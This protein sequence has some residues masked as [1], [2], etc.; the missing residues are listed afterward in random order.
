MSVT[1]YDFCGA[2]SEYESIGVDFECVLLFLCVVY[3]FEW[4]C[5]ILYDCMNDCVDMYNFV[6]CLCVTELFRV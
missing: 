5:V 6:N 2:V 1:L 4:W 3:K